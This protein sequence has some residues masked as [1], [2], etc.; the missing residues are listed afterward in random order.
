MRDLREKVR[1]LP[2][3]GKRKVY[4]I[5]EVHM[6]STSAFNALL[7]TLEEPPP[8]VV[9]IFATTEPEKIPETIKSRCQQFS[10]EPVSA[11]DLTHHL[12]RIIESEHI[13]LKEEE[14]SEI[15]EAIV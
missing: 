14:R 3:Q 8:K 4:I 6:L 1:I 12:E 7:K 15:I 11:E 5:D 10:F 13:S 2:A 9:F